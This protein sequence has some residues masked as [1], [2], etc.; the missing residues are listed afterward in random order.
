ME[1]G[2]FWTVHDRW[3]VHDKSKSRPLVGKSGITL[4]NQYLKF[5]FH[6]QL[7][8]LFRAPI[9]WLLQL[10]DF[11]SQ[12]LTLQLQAEWLTIVDR[13]PGRSLSRTQ[14]RGRERLWRACPTRATRPGPLALDPLFAFAALPE[15]GKERSSFLPIQRRIENEFEIRIRS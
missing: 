7:N 6:I 15:E 4:F 12:A 8:W 14:L 9:S 11:A 2:P 1:R 10:I 13:W 5:F 3:K